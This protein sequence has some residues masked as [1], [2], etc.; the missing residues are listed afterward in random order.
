MNHTQK[1]PEKPSFMSA[2]GRVG[3]VHCYSEYQNSL[4]DLW[5]FFYDAHANKIF[6]SGSDI[7]WEVRECP[8][9]AIAN[10]D[11]YDAMQQ[12][13][14]AGNIASLVLSLEERM[15][16]AACLRT[17]AQMRRM[18]QERKA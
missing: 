2:V 7:G 10:W 8:I 16:L 6:V 3:V 12:I 9:E 4:N 13:T 11:Q 15:W 17:V 14:I 1:F 5:G 18:F